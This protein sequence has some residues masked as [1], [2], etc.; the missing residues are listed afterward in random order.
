VIWTPGGS[1]DLI[2]HHFGRS[3]WALVELVGLELAVAVQLQVDVG[4]KLERVKLALQ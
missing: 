2:G 4:T 1:T 3:V